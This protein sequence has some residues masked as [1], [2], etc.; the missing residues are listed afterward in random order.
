M[1]L[2]GTVHYGVENIRSNCYNAS[3]YFD[4]YFVVKK[5]L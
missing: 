3:K 5:I 4:E 2:V 1:G